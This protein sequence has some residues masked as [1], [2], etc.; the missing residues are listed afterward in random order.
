MLFKIIYFDALFVELIT[1]N[2][3]VSLNAKDYADNF[4]KKMDFLDYKKHFAS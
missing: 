2:L 1:E 3:D 4:F